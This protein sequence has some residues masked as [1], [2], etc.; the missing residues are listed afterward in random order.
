MTWSFGWSMRLLQATPSRREQP[1]GV[2]A[3]ER[4]T[5]SRKP[6]TW[7]LI[8]ATLIGLRG[9]FV[10]ARLSIDLHAA[11]REPGT[12]IRTPSENCGHN[13]QRHK[14]RAVVSTERSRSRRSSADRSGHARRRLVPPAAVRQDSPR[15]TH[16]FELRTAVQHCDS[17]VRFEAFMIRPPTIAGKILRN[18]QIG[19]SSNVIGLFISKLTKILSQ[20]LQSAEHADFDCTCLASEQTANFLVPEI[21]KTAEDQHLPFI[22]RQL[23]ER[24]LQESDVLA[25]ADHLIC[26][27]LRLLPLQHLVGH[28]TTG[29]YGAGRNMRYGPFG[30][31]RPKM[32]CSRS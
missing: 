31:S 24:L 4:A 5:N 3:S 1:T 26:H 25:A 21:V 14:T 12:K 7:E 29:A 10:R 20:L 30:I 23:Q 19:Y 28:F 15:R 27:R 16:L 22:F 17:R 8:L 32:T 2:R 9:E 13:F 11:Q 6:W 18:Q